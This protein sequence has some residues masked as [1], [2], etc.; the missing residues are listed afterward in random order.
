M[1]K[2]DYDFSF[3]I[4][5]GTIEMNKFMKCSKQIGERRLLHKSTNTHAQR[6]KCVDSR[7]VKQTKVFFGMVD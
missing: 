4:S 6:P 7:A 5:E 3:L 2:M 1:A